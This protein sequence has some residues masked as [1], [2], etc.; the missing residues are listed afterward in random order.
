[1][2]IAF[3]WVFIVDSPTGGD[4][5]KPVSETGF[6]LPHRCRLITIKDVARA[7]GVSASTVSRVF[8]RP[9]IVQAETRRTVLEAA[10]Q[11][12]F[13]PNGLARALATGR[14]GLVGLVVPDITNPFFAYLARGIDDELRRNSLTLVL[15]NS[16]DND[17][18]EARLRALLEARSVDGFIYACMPAV[19]SLRDNR[20]PADPLPTV[21]IQRKPDQP[22]SDSVY[23]D[24][25]NGARQAAEYLVSLGHHRIGMLAGLP[26]TVSS[27]RRERAF[28]ASLA[29]RGLQLPR[30]W[31]LAHDFK[32][33]GGQSAADELLRLD[34][35]PT[36]IFA[37]SDLLAYGFIS[38][39]GELG[40]RVPHDVSVLSFDDLPLNSIVNPPLTSVCSPTHELGR[41]AARLLVER[42]AKPG[43]PSRR[44]TLG[45]SLVLRQSCAPPDGA[46]RITELS[47][48]ALP[49]GLPPALAEK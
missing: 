40:L 36:A 5:M 42:L 43:L 33:E 46:S 11:L 14:S 35:R 10:Q 2:C 25:N 32:F 27:E 6:T 19:V 1:M 21:Y 39:L 8:N 24:D 3:S 49:P 28:R 37:A 48:Q 7:S 29:H 23:L 18:E 26:G 45:V 34:P 47:A 4:I 22:N 44:R 20:N 38:R 41:T 13:V 17:A 30:E 12:G 16:A 9:G 31:V 15:C